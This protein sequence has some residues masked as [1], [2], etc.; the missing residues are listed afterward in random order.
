MRRLKIL[1]V[2]Y[3]CSPKRGSEPGM[4]WNFVVEI[5]KYHDVWV[6]AEQEKF[7]P[8]VRDALD[9]DPDLANRLRFR[10][11]KK[12]R[13]RTLRKIWPPSYYWFYQVW[14]RN[15]Y[16][17]ALEMHEKEQFDLLHQLNMV[18]FREP[19]YLWK[20]DAPFVWGPV[21]GM[22]LVPWR[23]LACLGLQGAVYYLARNILN[24][25]QQRLLPRPRR[26]ARKAVPG[27]IAATG[28]I[29]ARM[30]RFWSVDAS[31]I[32]EVGYLPQTGGANVQS[33]ADKE[34]LRIAWSGQHK[35]GKALAILLRALKDVSPEVDWSLHI[36]GEGPLTAKWKRIA[37][38]YGLIEGCS[39]HGWLDRSEAI[40]VMEAAHVCVITSVSDLTSTV[41]LEALS[42]G[43]PVIC[44]DHCG[45]A[46]VVTDTCGIKIPLTTPQKASAQIAQAIEQLWN[47]EELRRWLAQGAGER[48]K[49]YT[50]EKKMK[51]L[52]EIYANTV[53]QYRGE[54]I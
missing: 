16:R 39:W 18:G 41:T 42:L 17:L 38:R 40:E 51:V 27:V 14:H 36:L 34:P 21:G 5:A 10:F 19:G 1:I 23:F 26:A 4:G 49:L 12:N 31:V 48:A 7:E 35:A 37:G 2:A 45:F 32:C 6:I 15:A 25:A 11:I 53:A 8:E 44:L 47:D 24:A 9:Q 29:R 13:H 30:K 46:D 20:I 50:W 28:E 3:A 52:N 22:N 43:L 54:T 33:R